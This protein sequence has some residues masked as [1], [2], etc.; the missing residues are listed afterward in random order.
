MIKRSGRL[1]F[2]RPPLQTVRLP[3]LVLTIKTPE[4]MITQP[5]PPGGMVLVISAF[6]QGRFQQT[7]FELPDGSREPNGEI[8]VDGI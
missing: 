6:G 4:L 5:E 7:H 1:F 2:T 8:S 3:G